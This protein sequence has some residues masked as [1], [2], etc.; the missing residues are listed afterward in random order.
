MVA[1]HRNR[2]ARKQNGHPGHVTIVLSSLV[3]TTKQ[4]FVNRSSIEGRISRQQR[5]ERQC[6]QVV[7]AHGSERS[8]VTPDGRSYGVAN[9]CVGHGSSSVT[10][11]VAPEARATM[12]MRPDQVRTRTANDTAPSKYRPHPYRKMTPTLA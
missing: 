2:Q 9:E 8:T 1:G 3:R 12:R 6:G 5:G 11:G 7:G 10:V 4:H